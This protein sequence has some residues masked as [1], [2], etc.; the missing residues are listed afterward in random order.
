MLHT[1]AF[2]HA[3][4][5]VDN[6]VLVLTSKLE[7][8][9]KRIMKQT[10]DINSEGVYHDSNVTDLK[11]D[12]SVFQDYDGLRNVLPLGNSQLGNQH[13]AAWE[14]DFLEG[15]FYNSNNFRF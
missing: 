6:H 8:L 5:N 12:P 13:V 1:R 3:D 4:S 9:E 11:F 14:I 7:D 10:H 15:K 2:I